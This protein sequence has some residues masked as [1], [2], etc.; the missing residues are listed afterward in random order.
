MK[1]QIKQVTDF[2]TKHRF[3]VGETLS[4]PIPEVETELLVLGKALEAKG[5]QLRDESG[6]LRKERVGLVIE[7]AGE[8]AIALAQGDRVGTL[9]ALADLAYVV[10]GAAVAYGLPLAEAFEAVH[11]SNMTKAVRREGDNTL[12][13]KGETYEPPNLSRLLE[14]TP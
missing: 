8:L 12:R 1:E 10:V 2:H 14:E 6:M 3:A 4:K 9:D 13:D 7:E 11:R 5:K